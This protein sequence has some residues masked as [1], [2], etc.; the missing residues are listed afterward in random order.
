MHWLASLDFNHP[1]EMVARKA[2]S[3]PMK[4]MLCIHSVYA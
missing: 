3:R 2:L 1:A 4:S